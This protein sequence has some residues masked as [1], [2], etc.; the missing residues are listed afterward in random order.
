MV[1][2]KIGVV[3]CRHL[4]G[5]GC[6]QVEW[7]RWPL[8]WPPEGPA[9]G[10]SQ[11]AQSSCSKIDKHSILLPYKPVTSLSGPYNRAARYNRKIQKIIINL[12]AVSGHI[13]AVGG[14]EE[15]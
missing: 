1:G 14:G 12:I 2:K 7:S 15:L 13:V 3:F 6:P 10:G 11:T 5:R 9:P 4:G 8:A